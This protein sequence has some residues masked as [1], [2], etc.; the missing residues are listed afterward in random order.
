M[1]KASHEQI[2]EIL[3]TLPIGLYLGD[4]TPVVYEQA[5]DS[6]ANLMDGTIHV[7]GETV[8]HGLEHLPET[9]DPYGVENAVR[10][11]LYHELSHVIMTPKGLKMDGERIVNIF[12]DERIET[13][14]SKYYLGVNFKKMA[15]AVNG[16]TKNWKPTDARTYFYGIVRFRQGPEKFLRRVE[17][18]ISR[19]SGIRAF[20]S[21]YEADPYRN[22]IMRLWD[23]VRR[24]W[25]QN[26]EQRQDEQEQR[27]QER[28]QKEEQNQQGQQGQQGQ[29]G[30]GGSQKDK[31]D[32]KQGHGG[33]QQ[34][35]SA[36][37]D[38]DKGGSNGGADEKQDNGESDNG[39]QGDDAGED[40][41]E[42]D[43]NSKGAGS[44]G[45][46]ADKQESGNED[47]DSEGQGDGTDGDGMEDAE[48]GANGHGK[49]GG[50]RDGNAKEQ[51]SKGS[52]DGKGDSADG[53]EGEAEGQA[54]DEGEQESAGEREA[55][56]RAENGNADD[57]NE[58]TR[59]SIARDVK[60]LLGKFHDEKVGHV[61]ERLII[62]HNKKRASRTP[63]SRG[64]TGKVGYKEVATR[65]DY[66]W[67]IR[68][69]GDGE[70]KFGSTHFTLWVDCSGSF[71]Y[72]VG[73]INSVIHELNRLARRMGREFSFDVVQM[74]MRNKVV[75]TT[76]E[77]GASGC[78]GF[79]PGVEE[80]IRKTRKQGC[81]NYNVV[82][83]DGD[84]FSGF[85][86]SARETY[87]PVL[88]KAFNN[89]N[90]VIVT[91][92]ENEHY[93]RTNTPNAR[94]KVIHDNYA[95]HFV[96]ALL[97]LLAQVLV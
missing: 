73:R 54:Q 7:S 11:I 74:T 95:T 61:L 37:K 35:E 58:I 21:S 97:E 75:P 27:N 64:Y 72:E 2:K 16:W 90:T 26:Q 9:A 71:C 62:Q 52:S 81:N 36:D 92:G 57:I 70:N 3:K 40:N 8:M 49:T 80:C 85:S 32:Q 67:F 82:V 60:K 25:N 89:Q 15:M 79:G 5:G 68:K 48:D 59:E 76:V 23:D 17:H 42:Q 41:G 4:R 14:L 83:W 6:Y 63:M 43:G 10:C 30:N 12:E 20:S 94:V 86:R 47:G 93:T 19:F 29:S 44:E 46:D 87:L 18:I 51:Q 22:E 65:Q 24:D 50:D 66:R 96:D 45:D 69:G 33:G 77:L 31:G 34:N 1:L 84:M 28:N 39:S 38:Q 88:R 91:D 56:E 78:N 55:R 53:E 13:L